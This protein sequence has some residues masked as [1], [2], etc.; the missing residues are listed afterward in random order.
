MQT[1]RL[2][3]DI[4]TLVLLS[5]F[6]VMIFVPPTIFEKTL[7][8]RLIPRDIFLS[9]K[10][11]NLTLSSTK[12]L[13]TLLDGA[14]HN[15]QAR[16]LTKFAIGFT[17]FFSI[18]AVRTYNEDTANSMEIAQNYVLR[19]SP[20]FSYVM[21][22]GGIVLANFV[23]YG[24][25]NAMMSIV[26]QFYPKLAEVRR[27][28]NK[29]GWYF[30]ALQLFDTFIPLVPVSLLNVVFACIGVPLH[31]F[32]FSVIHTSLPDLYV[33]H[34]WGVYLSEIVA[35]KFVADLPYLFVVLFSIGDCLFAC[36]LFSIY[37]FNTEAGTMPPQNYSVDPQHNET[38][39]KDTLVFK[40]KTTE[41]STQS[42]ETKPLLEKKTD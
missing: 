35:L 34:F 18:V 40:D 4:I 17:Y 29:F 28:C 15:T 36:V 12:T 16:G 14:V 7:V 27:F 24:I 6:L 19:G 32:L 9:A 21:S 2:F 42:N 1:Q 13:G 41:P 30:S 25:I 37:L 5:S 8:P 22:I 10:T 3:F 31:N 11:G 23:F 39:K 38:I 20:V 33:R 26:A